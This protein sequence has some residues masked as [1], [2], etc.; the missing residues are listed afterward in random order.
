MDLGYCEGSK[1]EKTALLE[2]AKDKNQRRKHIAHLSNSNRS[3]DERKQQLA[4]ATTR[5]TFVG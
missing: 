5:A 2:D 4:A 1:S 3:I